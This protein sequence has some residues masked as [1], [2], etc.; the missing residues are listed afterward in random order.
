MHQ[1]IVAISYRHIISD[2]KRDNHSEPQW[3]EEFRTLG[4]KL[5]MT[6]QIWCKP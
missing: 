4:E 3:T 5:H 2:N 6:R 1:T